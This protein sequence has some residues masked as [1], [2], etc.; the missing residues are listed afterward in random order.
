MPGI[1]AI[2]ITGRLL[3]KSIPIGAD[4]ALVSVMTRIFIINTIAGTGRGGIKDSMATVP[5][6]PLLVERFVLLEPR[7]VTP[8]PQAVL[9]YN[10]P[11]SLAVGFVTREP[12]ALA[13]LSLRQLLPASVLR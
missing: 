11:A 1:N 8:G 13:V 3:N 6:Q 5:Q 10:P 2:L 9:A 7:F 4:I 12:Q